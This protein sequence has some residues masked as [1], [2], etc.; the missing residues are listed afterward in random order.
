MFF[1]YVPCVVQAVPGPDRTVYAYFSD[2][3]IRQFDVRPLIDGGG[4]FDAL[5]DD[6]FFNGRLTVLNGS[7][8]WDVSGH[9]DP[10]TCIDL[11]PYVVYDAPAV[12]DPL[13]RIRP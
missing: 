9:F 2:G 1:E 11:D 13:E 7:V 6:D 4:V 3:A 10:T 12:A 5:R 8:A